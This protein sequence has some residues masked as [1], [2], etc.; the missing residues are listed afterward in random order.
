[1]TGAVFI[2]RIMM[3]MMRQATCRQALCYHH[4]KTVHPVRVAGRLC[5]PQTY[6]TSPPQWL[7]GQSPWCEYGE[8]IFP[9]SL[10]SLLPPFHSHRYVDPTRPLSC[11]SWLES[12]CRLLQ[13][14]LLG[15]ALRGEAFL[16]CA[17]LAGGALT[18]VTSSH[19]AVLLPRLAN[20]TSHVTVLQLLST[21]QILA[22]A[23]V[24]GPLLP[25]QADSSSHQDDSPL[26]D[27][28]SES[29]ELQV[30]RLPQAVLLQEQG[31]Q[32]AAG[33]DHRHFSSMAV[34]PQPADALPASMTTGL[35]LGI[36][37]GRFE[38]SPEPW[39]GEDGCEGGVDGTLSGDEFGGVPTK[40][41]GRHLG[42]P[43]CEI[44]RAAD[45]VQARRLVALLEMA[46]EQ[47]QQ[48]RGREGRC[49]ML[50]F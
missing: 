26:N 7:D 33:I 48:R 44:V 23:V 37:G 34:S 15:G 40:A 18:I 22:A 10:I 39:C 5:V 21:E 49:L 43:V 47:E 29:C 35:V 50:G 9:I 20:E 8:L 6:S 11:Y 2:N 31:L 3:M 27:G 13:H 46:I 28:D 19:W 17:S 42:W 36:E 30:L 14:D 16:G 25:C 38:G 45:G 4:I 24:K 41:Q 12:Y 32:L 1:M